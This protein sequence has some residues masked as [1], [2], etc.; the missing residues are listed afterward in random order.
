MAAWKK[1]TPLITTCQKF[2]KFHFSVFFNSKL[3]RAADT[4]QTIDTIAALSLP[5]FDDKPRVQEKQQVK[6][7]QSCIF[8]F[9]ACLT[10]PSSN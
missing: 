4:K 9:A 7:Q 6:E 5:H 3:G 2:L 10:I 1:C 8:A